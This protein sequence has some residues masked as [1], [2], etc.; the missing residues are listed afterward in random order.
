MNKTAI[1][2]VKNPDGTPGYTWNPITGCRNHVEG[3]CRAGTFPCYAYRLANGRLKNRMLANTCL[4]HHLPLAPDHGGHHADPFYPRFWQSRVDNGSDLLFA[5][6]KRRYDKPMGVFVCSMGD[7]FGAGVPEDWTDAVM[8]VIRDAAAHSYHRF[9]L[10]TKQPQ[11]L[12]KWSPFPDNC[13]V[14]VSATDQTQLY[15]AEEHLADVQAS[16]K[17]ISMEPLLGWDLAC[18]L[19]IRRHWF[20][21]V[22]IGAQTK[23]YIAPKLEW[24]GE[25]DHAATQANIPIFH[26]DS[27]R[28]IVPLIDF[29]QEM[30]HD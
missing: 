22:I 12:A 20:D 30:P 9:Y 5:G 14:G 7:L 15:T 4:A 6:H 18:Q 11:N 21:W 25:I 29:R 23:P 17:Y 3:M 13:W 16:V 10:L 26:K 24:L 28:G 27:L 19:S 2:W 8:N 1:E